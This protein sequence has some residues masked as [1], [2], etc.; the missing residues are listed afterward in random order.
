MF[1]NS[2][3]KV[4][5]RSVELEKDPNADWISQFGIQS[6]TDLDFVLSQIGWPVGMSRTSPPEFRRRVLAAAISYQLQLRSID[7]ALKRYVKPNEYEAEQNSLGDIVSDFLS[8]STAT[9]ADEL[10]KFHSKE[11]FTF[12]QFGAEITLFRCPEVVNLARMLANR[13]VFLEVLPILRLCLEMISWSAVANFISDEAKVKRLRAGACITKIKEI[14]GSVGKVYG[15]LSKFSHWEQEIHTYFLN[16]EAEQVAV[17]QASCQ[18]RAMSLT[19]CLVILDIFVEVIRYLYSTSAGTL[20]T[21]IQGIPD[22]TDG[23]RI[24]L[25]ISDIVEFSRCQ[26]LRQIQ[27]LLR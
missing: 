16:I 13:G 12:G 9:L 20:I 22:R 11:N 26:D 23:R 14:Y 27:S 8:H 4:A 18:H 25:L 5:S 1:P 24:H 2:Q 15:Y 17:I 21:S 6:D 3:N 19:L 10:W 7:Y